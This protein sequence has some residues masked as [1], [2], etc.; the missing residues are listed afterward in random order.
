[1][2]DKFKQKENILNT[3]DSILKKYFDSYINDKKENIV[4]EISDNN[5][6]INELSLDNEK[7]IIEFS[8]I[9]SLFQCISSQFITSDLI[10]IKEKRSNALYT[11]I[12]FDKND[13][14]KFLN[15]IQI[16]GSS[17]DNKYSKLN[18]IN[19]NVENIED[20]ISEKELYIDENLLALTE[21][22]IYIKN[23]KDD[24][25]I[26]LNINLFKAEEDYENKI[27]NICGFFLIC[28]NENN[29]FTLSHKKMTNGI[30]TMYKVIPW[31]F[32]SK[33]DNIKYKIILYNNN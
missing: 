30:L 31:N 32:L 20:I 9:N 6:N 17:S 19:N 15:N 24:A 10:N 12:K 11:E 1:M 23:F 5:K 27:D 16:N 14:N 7:N 3:N 2:I 33:N 13:L 28:Q 8:N 29:T 25:L 21:A 22:S 4:N 26:Q 18:N